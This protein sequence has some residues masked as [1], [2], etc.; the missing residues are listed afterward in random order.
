[1]DIDQLLTALTGEV[2]GDFDADGAVDAA[3]IDALYANLGDPAFDL[4]GDS[5]ADQQDVDLLVRIILNTEYGDANFDGQVDGTDLSILA[6]GFGAGAGWA[7]GDFN[8]DASIDGT[9]LS[10]LATGFGFVASGD[11]ILS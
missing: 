7:M 9:D 10:I 6:G 5:D 3:D 8:G 1:M 11:G 4:D 2:P